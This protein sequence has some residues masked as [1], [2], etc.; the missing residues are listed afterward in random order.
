[1]KLARQKKEI[2][3]PPTNR[4]AVKASAGKKV[5]ETPYYHL[6]LLLAEVC[7][8][9]A[10]ENNAYCTLGS[11]KKN[12]ALTFSVTSGDDRQTLYD[13]SLLGLSEQAADLHD[14]P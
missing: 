10:Q 7:D 11:T 14:A 2:S 8:E 12:D 5:S 13:V 3:L 4:A 6:L 1:M 9:N